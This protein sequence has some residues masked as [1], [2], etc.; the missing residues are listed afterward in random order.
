MSD[1]ES[2]ISSAVREAVKQVYDID[3]DDSIL[4]VETP[5][6]PKM[7]DYS[8]SVAMRLSRTLHKSPLDIA[9]PIVEKLKEI[10][11]EASSIEAVKPGFINFRLK[12]DAL[13]EVINTVINAGDDYG[14]NNT[15]AGVNVLVE[16]VSANPT[17]DL[18]CGHAR[19]AAWGDC[20]SRLYE[21]SGYNNYSC[22]LYTSIFVKA[23]VSMITNADITDTR[24]D[25]NLCGFVSAL[26]NLNVD[27][28]HTQQNAMF[29]AWFDEIK[30]QL[31]TDLAGNLQNQINT[32]KSEQSQL[33]QR[34]YPIGSLYISE[35]TVSP[36]TLFGFGRWEKIEDRFL[37]GAGKNM[38]I[39]SKGGSTTHTHGSRD[40][41]NGN[42]SAAIGAVNG[43]TNAIGYKAANDTDLN[44]LGN[45][46]F[47]V[48]GAGQG[49]TGWNHFTAVVGQTAADDTLPPYYAV[50]IWRRVA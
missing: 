14:K 5:R 48:S 16:W 10:Y 40:G 1:F 3:A 24:I 4:I 17:G 31:G 42:L 23:N 50:N 43:N 37:I 29:N 46:T 6:D 32:L 47:V 44:A 2:K 30:G 11:T 27:S 41:R 18:H 39:K 12:K 35:S 22:L 15:G 28:L 38:P 25:K 33:L 21:A 8:T 36:A 49:F 7:G 34:V 9:G 19:N 26:N 20:I 13:A 45:A